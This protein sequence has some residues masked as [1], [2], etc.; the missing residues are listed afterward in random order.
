MMLINAVCSTLYRTFK[1]TMSCCPWGSNSNGGNFNSDEGDTATIVMTDGATSDEPPRSDREREVE[2]AR[3]QHG[4]ET[5]DN[6]AGT[7]DPV[8][9][10]VDESSNEVVEDCN[11]NRI[12]G[13]VGTIV[14][15]V[16]ADT[17][18]DMKPR[19]SVKAATAPFRHDALF[20]TEKD[21]DN[22]Y[23]KSVDS[24]V[25]DLGSKSG[26]NS[27]DEE[28]DEASVGGVEVSN[29]GVQ[30]LSDADTSSFQDASTT[31]DATVHK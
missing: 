31:H 16:V 5:D 28:A 4:S 10:C 14:V 2:G 26:N 13:F 23:D 17:K 12:E 15:D 7:N 3:N 11:A 27:L 30:V 25:D 8:N 6:L 18:I 20:V 1:C 19:V 29:A 24:S 22:E 9:D 21:D